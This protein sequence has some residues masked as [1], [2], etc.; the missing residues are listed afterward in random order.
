MP[1]LYTKKWWSNKFWF[2]PILQMRKKKTMKK[3]KT[4]KAWYWF[5]KDGN[6]LYETL[7]FTEKEALDDSLYHKEDGD[8]LQK[9]EIRIPV[10][11]QRI[12]K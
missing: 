10:K 6:F 7:C 1:T 2:N 11:S 9:V 12:K 3:F 4:V 5:S 8:Y